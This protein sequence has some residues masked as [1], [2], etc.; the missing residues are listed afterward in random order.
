MEPVGAPRGDAMGMGGG[1][2]RGRSAV[3][4]ASHPPPAVLS[5]CGGRWGEL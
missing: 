3:L 2:H 4:C 1:W 5:S